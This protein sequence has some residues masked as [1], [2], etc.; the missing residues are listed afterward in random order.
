MAEAGARLW[1]FGP[2]PAREET[3]R[4]VGVVSQIS[5]QPGF[6]GPER[7]PDTL[8]GR[9]EIV[10]LNG[11][12][13]LIRLQAEG[14]AARALTQNFTDALFRHFDHGLREAGVG[15]LS[16]PKRMR[17]LA[18]DFYGRL[19]AYAPALAAGDRPGLE[20]ALRRN[21][22]PGAAAPFAAELGR[23]A[24]ESHALQA[25]LPVSALARLDSWAAAPA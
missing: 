7:A 8:E 17:R 13:V 23:Y 22:L 1:P 10:T 16:V 20:A 19:G 21:V 4:L 15:D 3:L 24:A 9:A 14:D 25:G 2:S 11:C 18:S 5:R 6:F 12:L